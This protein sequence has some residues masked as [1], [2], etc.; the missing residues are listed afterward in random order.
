MNVHFAFVAA[1]GIAGAETVTAASFT[2]VFGAQVAFAIVIKK[3]SFGL[4][5]RVN[6]WMEIVK[7]GGA[8]QR[9]V[10]NKYIG[11]KKKGLFG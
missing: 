9:L 6:M 8:L 4:A 5:R 11:E 1:P 10:A 2:A 3:P 7:N